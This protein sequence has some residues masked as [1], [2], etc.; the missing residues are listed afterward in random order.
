MH[1]LYAGVYFNGR[2]TWLKRLAF[3]P[4]LSPMVSILSTL[5]ELANVTAANHELPR[6]FQELS[7]KDQARLISAVLT[8]MRRGLMGYNDKE[9]PPLLMQVRL[10]V[11]KIRLSICSPPAVPRD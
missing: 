6:P 4:E 7:D 3:S 5:A 11:E 8:G 1:F 2:K 10:E 9:E